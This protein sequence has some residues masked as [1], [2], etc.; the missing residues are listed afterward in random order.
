MGSRMQKVS[1]Y[2]VYYKIH[3]F[4]KIVTPSAKFELADS[5]KLFDDEPD[6]ESRLKKVKCI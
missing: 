6:G 3:S 5:H 4:N 1:F 2:V